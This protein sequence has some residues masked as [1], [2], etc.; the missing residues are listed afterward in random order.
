M[1]SPPRL[2]R[3]GHAV[4]QLQCPTTVPN[5]GRWP[6]LR[7]ISCSRA[8]ESNTKTP[9]TRL[10]NYVL[11]NLFAVRYLQI[12]PTLFF[13]FSLYKL[14]PAEHSVAPIA[15]TQAEVLFSFLCLFLFPPQTITWQQ[16]VQ[17]STGYRFDL[18]HLRGIHSPLH[19][20]LHPYLQTG[21]S[22]LD[23]SLGLH[24]QI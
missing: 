17:W 13:L 10:Q 8:T 21:P 6:A 15:A 14:T 11:Y 20:R 2:S 18:H 5:C 23:L 7:P 24:A 3:D 9:P 12:S 1:Q 16:S 19:H 4:P 22:S